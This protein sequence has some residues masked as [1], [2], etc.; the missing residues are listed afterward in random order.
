MKRDE[1]RNVLLSHPSTSQDSLEVACELKWRDKADRLLFLILDALP[2]GNMYHSEKNEK[3]PDSCRCGK[4]AQSV[5]QIMKKKNISYHV[6][7]CSNS[8][9]MIITEFKRYIDV[10]ML[11]FDGKITFEG[12]IAKQVYQQLVG[13]EMTFEQIHMY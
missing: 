3:C 2:H 9:N 7:R 10:K 1:R 11:T 6:L 8:L 4:T 13:T 5:L 12:V